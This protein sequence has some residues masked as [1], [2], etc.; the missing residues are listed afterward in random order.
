MSTNNW[1]FS[2]AGKSV[3]PPDSGGLGFELQ[4]IDK[5]ERNANGDA[6]IEEVNLK[7]KLNA[8]WSSLD[9]EQASEIFATLENNRVG[10]FKY[11]DIAKGKVNTIQ[12]YYGAGAKIGYLRYDDDLEKQR[13]NAV[14]VN[15]IEM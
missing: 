12:A 15:F 13:Y 9:G 6:T 8:S 10:E 1:V 4:P 14:S 3:P 11:F 2:Y 5:V 7:R